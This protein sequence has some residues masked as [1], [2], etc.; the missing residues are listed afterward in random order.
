MRSATIPAFVVTGFLGSGKTTLL[1]RL[2][3]DP[4]F[5]DTAVIVNEFGT[6]GLDHELLAFASE[7]I[8]VLPGGCLCCSVRE[9]MEATLSE[10]F[11][12][13]AS[14][15]VPRFSRLVIETTG[16][17]EPGPLLFTLTASP[18]AVGRLHVEAVVTVV[19]A[20]LAR[21]SEA[22]HGEWEKQVA[23]ADRLVISKGD[24]V[25]R[26]DVARLR[27]RLRAI[28]PWAD[29]RT[30]N[31]LTAEPK[32]LFRRAR[33]LATAGH[34]LGRPATSSSAHRSHSQDGPTLQAVSLAYDVPLDWT[35]F[36]VWLTLLLHRH[37]ERIPRIKGL[38][39]VSG[40]PGP[41]AIHAVQHIVHPPQHF[42]SWP[43][44]DRRS[45]LVFIAHG[46]G[47]YEI[48][49]SLGAFNSA[50]RQEAPASESETYRPA[51]AGGTI[52]GRPVRRNTAPRWMKG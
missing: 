23:V 22:T 49:R 37:G 43:S 42:D 50:A 2:L 5:A 19:D 25:P 51:G 47:A 8:V 44:A 28:N 30:M 33:R 41:V 9:D 16:L 18:V 3:Q 46:I 14:G 35:A 13:V 12:G 11:N 45:R 36:G 7:R 4:G 52:A 6:V 1:Q 34:S 32:G 48:E 20:L 17:A 40:L 15:Q 29:I 27:A 24:L 10:L 38:L 31:L 39:N 26:A 21:M